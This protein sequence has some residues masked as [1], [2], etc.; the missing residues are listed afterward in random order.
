MRQG[1][2]SPVQLFAGLGCRRGCPAAVLADLLEQTLQTHGLALD[3]LAGLAS[4]DLKHDEPGLHELAARLNLP[5]R[6]FPASELTPFASRL[7]HRSTTAFAHSGCF[8]VAESAALALTEALTGAPATLC[9]PRT[10]AASASVAVAWA[11]DFGG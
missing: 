10:L 11:A 3:A 8:G 6:F 2:P 1:L 7:S 5:L 9:I 4:I